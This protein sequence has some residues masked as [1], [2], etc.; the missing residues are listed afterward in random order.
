MNFTR[1][2]TRRDFLC[3]GCRTLSTIGA[4]AALGQAGLMTARAQSSGDYKALVCI[5]LFGGNDANNLLIPDD[6]AGYA[7]YQKIR[8]NLAIAR[9][10][11]PM[12]VE[13]METLSRR[14]A[15][16]AGDGH[17]ELY[18]ST[19]KYDGDIGRGQHGLPSHKDLP[20]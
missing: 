13:E 7:A 11:Q 9:G 6:T 15:V 1:I 12:T 18:K 20:L 16:A 17:L 4:A 14:C 8:Q 10:F 3:Y 19:M 2:R 5:F